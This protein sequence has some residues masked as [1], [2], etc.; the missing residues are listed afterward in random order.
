MQR[1]VHSMQR[2]VHM[3]PCSVLLYML[4]SSCRAGGPMPESHA[5]GP[6]WCAKPPPKLKAPGSTYL[7]D[8]TPRKP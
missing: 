8:L 1:Y 7:T 3:Q 6:P 4:L 2:Y 5:W